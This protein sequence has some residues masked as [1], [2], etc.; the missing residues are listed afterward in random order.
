MRMAGTQEAQQLTFAGRYRRIR[1][2][3]TGGMARVF[4]AEDEVLGRQVA[5][6]QLPSAAPEE[7]LRRFRREARLGASLNHPNIVAIFDSVIDEDSVLIVMEFVEGESLADRMR[8]G[9]VDEREALPILE[10]VAAALDHAHAQGVVHR[11]IKP[12]NILIGADGSAK[13]ADLGIATAVDATA[14][15]GSGDVIGTLAYIA[16]ERLRGEPGDAAAD[17]YS[18]AA[19]AFEVLSGRRARPEKTPQQILRTADERPAP[20]L[21]D[22][23]PNASPAAAEVLREAMSSEPT[24]RPAS[25]GELVER[26]G[27]ALETGTVTQPRTTR[28]PVAAAAGVP[29][30]ASERAGR[31]P[32]EPPEWAPRRGG[33]FRPFAIAGL[34]IAVGL[35]IGVLLLS[36]GDGGGGSEPVAERGSGDRQ[37]AKQADQGA[38]NEEPSPAPEEPAAEPAPEPPPPEPAA[39]EPLSAEELDRQG[40]ALID[41]GQPAAAIPILQRAVDAADPSTL[42]YA[43]ALFNL[44]NALR[45]AG[46]PE[47]A[48]PILEA[49]LEIPNQRGVVKRELELAYAEAGISPDEGRGNRGHGGSRGGDGEGDED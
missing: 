9:R 15:T 35:L 34:G 48:I 33:G 20:D 8:R 22:A 41:S 29:A 30:S 12:S 11:D 43:F 44:G 4:L 18:L 32:F 16:P 31:P 25:A 42:T 7:A 6:K 17:V 27:T 28:R 39:E 2:I 14:I 21:M 3:G 46:R 10:Q 40:K 23:D 26:L 24:Q 47:E 36:D 5:V 37:Q 13:V 38:A 1:R 45:L 19:V 49:R